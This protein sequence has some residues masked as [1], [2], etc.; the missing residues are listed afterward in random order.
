M[1]VQHRG[2][3]YREKPGKS[4]Y[5]VLPEKLLL[6]LKCSFLS[7]HTRQ[8]VIGFSSR[9]A[10]GR[11]SVCQNAGSF[12]P[13]PPPPSPPLPLPGRSPWPTLS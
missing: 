9:R 11:V 7:S 6:L 1:I 2:T 13:S 10:T 12:V 3:H 4:R 8:K 5:K